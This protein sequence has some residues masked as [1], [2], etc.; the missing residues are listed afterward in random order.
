M[1]TKKNSKIPKKRGQL[2]LDEQK[3]IRENFS[4]LTIEE[5]AQNLNRSQAPIKKYISDNSLSEDS[6]V[7]S[8]IRQKLYGKS[9]WS[10]IQKQFDD[11]SGELQYFEETWIN[12]IK[13]FREDVLPAEDYKSNSSL[14]SIY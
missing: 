10:E 11:S 7:D 3:Y 12:L 5:I 6:V 8:M 1:T 9:F 13:Q 4:T 2:A 14:L